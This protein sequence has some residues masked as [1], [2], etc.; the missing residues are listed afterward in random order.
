MTQVA[1][2]VD[3]ARILLGDEAVALGAIDAGIAAAYSYPGTPA[4]EIMETILAAAPEG[5]TARWTVNEKTAYEAALGVSMA[6][7]R[8]LVAMKH[9]G[10]NV[11]ADPFINSA[12]VAIGGGLV[13]AVADDPGMHS[14]QNE[15]DSR[16]LADFARIAC[17]EP[18]DQQEAY[19]MTREA[20]DVSER[21]HIPVLLRLV[22]RIAHSRS[23]VTTAP[24]LPP[25][26]VAKVE[27]VADW[28][29]IP[30]NARRVWRRLLGAQDDLQEWSEASPRNTLYLSQDDRGLGVITAG[31]GRNHYLENLPDLGFIPSHLHI[32]AYPVPAAAVRSLA[33]RVERILIF[34]EGYPFIERSIAGVLPT[35]WE[36]LGKAPGPLPLDG[37]LTPDTVRTALGLPERPRI[38]VAGLDL[39]ARPP[40]LCKGCPHDDSFR[41]LLAAVGGDDGA[42]VMSDI[43]CYA[44]GALPP[45]EAIESCVCMGASVGM[46]A[47][48]SAA[49]LRPALAVIGDSTFLHSGV[50]PLIDAVA[51]DTDM[52]LLILDNETVGM[53]G[54][55]P[56]V[57][58][59]SRLEPLIAGLGVDREHLHVLEITPKRVGELTGMLRAEMAH[60]GLS[61]IIAVREC[62]EAI[63]NRHR[64]GKS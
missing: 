58:P 22:T 33:E 51:H 61:V 5:V 62:V 41:A 53:T 54:Q 21:F 40:Q 42:V 28:I 18:A 44:L 15:Q 45:Y 8:A 59:G 4:T 49:G 30:S 63:K 25:G 23:L 47:G 60:P 39:P 10:L 55:Q 14:S 29:L 12:L 38:T 50:T 31:I 56:T 36:V 57:L 37:E 17:L 11:A 43:G 24:P 9:V 52:T 35:R 32:G 3:A 26:P 64:G 27:S 1:G 19:E 48:A 6:G 13:V 2:R 46:A 7:R 34:E 16:Y 20:F